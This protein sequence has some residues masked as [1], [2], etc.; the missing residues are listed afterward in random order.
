MTSK[1][2]AAIAFLWGGAMILSA[3]TKGIPMPTSSY[4]AGG[5]AAFLFGVAL[6]ALGGW[7]LFIRRPSQS[8]I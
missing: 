1:I 8:A 5:F 7:A 2:V 4:G 3:L 6:F